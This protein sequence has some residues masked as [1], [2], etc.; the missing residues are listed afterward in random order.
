MTKTLDIYVYQVAPEGGMNKQLPNISGTISQNEGWW[1]LSFTYWPLRSDKLLETKQWQSLKFENHC[2]SYS[3]VY[4]IYDLGASHILIHPTLSV[5][6]IL[7]GGWVNLCDTKKLN[8]KY[9]FFFL[10]TEKYS[11]TL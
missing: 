4:R 5:I 3:H 10:K 1:K 8:S 6:W 9:R 2:D 7:M 11:L